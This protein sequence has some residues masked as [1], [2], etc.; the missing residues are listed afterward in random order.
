[1]RVLLVFLC[2]A[3]TGSVALVADCGRISFQTVRWL[4]RK[5]KLAERA[6]PAIN[7]TQCYGLAF[8]FC[9]KYNHV[10]NPFHLIFFKKW[11]DRRKKCSN[12]SRKWRDSSKKCRMFRRKCGIFVKK[13]RI[14]RRKCRM[15]PKKCGIFRRKWGIFRRNAVRVQRNAVRAQRNAE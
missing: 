1:M 13:W 8:I 15:F 7:A 6:S 11:R 5:T 14:C 4:R 9:F 12:S 2:L 3:I 10:M